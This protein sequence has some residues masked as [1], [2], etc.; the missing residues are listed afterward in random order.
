MINPD[1]DVGKSVSYNFFYI[2]KRTE[3]FA[4][5]LKEMNPFANIFV[6]VVDNLE[7]TLT[8][9]KYSAVI[10]GFRTFKEA[11]LINDTCRQ[12]NVPF[13]ALNTSGLFGFFYIDVGKEMT[14]VHHRK[15]TDTDETYTITDSK[16]F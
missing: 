2:F 7:N 6:N 5:R 16:T 13:Y 8:S 12:M 11:V 9:H 1:D 15:A 4:L 14:F 10:Y 3:V